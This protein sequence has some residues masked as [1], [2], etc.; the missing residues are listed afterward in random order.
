MLDNASPLS[1]DFSINSK[2]DASLA[3]RSIMLSRAALEDAAYDSIAAGKMHFTFSNEIKTLPVANQ[4]QS[5][6][7]WIFVALNVLR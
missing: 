6:R 4:L 3:A 2:Q 7:C 1:T 5:G